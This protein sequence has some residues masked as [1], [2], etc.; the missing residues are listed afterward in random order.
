M[1]APRW[2]RGAS[3]REL[4]P[5]GVCVQWANRKLDGAGFMSGALEAGSIVGIALA[6]R[7]EY[8]LTSSL[9]SFLTV[10]RTFV[11][12]TWLHSPLSMFFFFFFWLFRFSF[13]R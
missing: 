13:A 7:V 1:R 6:R 2:A 8:H 10:F 11:I 4:F 12:Q 9:P 3:M 5:F